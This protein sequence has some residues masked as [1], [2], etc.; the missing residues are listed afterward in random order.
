LDVF[1]KE[2]YEPSSPDRDLR[3]LPNVIATPHMGS[4]TVE[5]CERMARAAL[6]NV[7]SSLSPETLK[8][9]PS[10]LEP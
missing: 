4:A 2:P 8:G 10:R 6:E 7:R 9:L 3:G 5:A 1:K